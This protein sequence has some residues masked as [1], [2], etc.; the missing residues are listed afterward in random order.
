MSLR[1][2]ASAGALFYR[3]RRIAGAADGSAIYLFPVQIATAP[4]ETLSEPVALPSKAG[5]P[6]RSGVIEIELSSGVR[7]SVDES[8]SMTTLRLVMSVLRR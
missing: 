7:V 3:W 1:D 4:N 2:T 8:V 6:R 5:T